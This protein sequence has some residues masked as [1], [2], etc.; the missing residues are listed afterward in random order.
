MIITVLLLLLVLSFFIH[1]IFIVLY[2]TGQT[3]E[4]KKRQFAG[5]IS[6]AVTNFLVMCCISYIALNRPEYIQEVDLKIILWLM[7]GLA[8]LFSFFLQAG[9]FVRVYKRAQDPEFFYRNF[10]GKKVYKKGVIKQY[11]FL[12]MFATIPVFLLIGAYFV[13]RLINV[14]LY[15]RL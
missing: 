5:F 4:Q 11:E 15:G 7:S 3:R 12:I 9:I 1:I 6:T 8:L 13:A 10:F 14:I 2:I